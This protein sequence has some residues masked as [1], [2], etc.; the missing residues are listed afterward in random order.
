[1]IVTAWCG[2]ECASAFL[3]KSCNVGKG[4]T[5]HKFFKTMFL[6]K[7][8]IFSLSWSRYRLVFFSCTHLGEKM[9]LFCK[10]FYLQNTDYNQLNKC[11]NKRSKNIFY[12]FLGLLG[13]IFLF[14]SVLSSWINVPHVK[15]IKEHMSDHFL[16]CNHMF[17]SLLASQIVQLLYPIIGNV[18]LN[19]QSK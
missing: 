3:W 17:K 4:V 15:Q 12:F 8:V 1:M 18:P 5:S 19:I 7:M 14:T 6:S 2:A 13:P 16:Y 9:V 10:F 11:R